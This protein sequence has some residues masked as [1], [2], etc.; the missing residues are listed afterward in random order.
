MQPDITIVI[1]AYNMETWL[2]TAIESCIWQTEPNIEIIIIDDGST[3]N[4]PN[5]CDR[6]KSLDHRIKTVH[7]Y[8]KGIGYTRQVGQEMAKGK[9]V[10][11]LDADDFLDKN[12]ARDM[13]YTAYRDKVD[14]VCGNAIV[15]SNVTFNCRR[16]FHHPEA[17]NITFGKSPA[18]W[19]SKVA[20]RWIFKTDFIRK[21]ALYHLPY[22]LSQDVCFMYE[23]LTRVDSFS[24]CPSFFYY[25]RQEHKSAGV[26]IE[27]KI[28]HQLAHFID[29]K[30]TLVQAGTIK[31]LIKYLMENYFRDI[32]KIMPKLSGNDDPWVHRSMEI[33]LEIFEGLKPSW[34]YPEYLAPELKSEPDLIPLAEALIAKNRSLV[35][36]EFERWRN[37]G[38]HHTSIDKSNGFH[39]LRRQIKSYFNPLSIKA[40]ERLRKLKSLASTR[41]N[42][43]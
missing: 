17:H 40:K 33:S 1:P 5:I 16:Y 2:P 43:R 36:T 8:N 24:Q 42:Q 35:L 6:Y 21:H 3:D 37:A 22:K 28:E 15:F 9:Y 32:K 23:A 10:T 41:F 38:R 13:L 12:A 19:K 34:F 31:P 18:Y 39:T 14:M 20:W 27:T 25:F 26:S 7:Q 11:W 30:K 4:T 29:V